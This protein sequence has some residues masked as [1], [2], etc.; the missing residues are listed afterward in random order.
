MSE[1]ITI[2]V[3]LSAS[4][5][6]HL[7]HV[8]KVDGQTLSDAVRLAILDHVQARSRNRSFQARAKLWDRLART[9]TERS[10]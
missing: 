7:S 6:A 5:H 10:K 4:L 8:A 3:R 1:T 2:T 9:G